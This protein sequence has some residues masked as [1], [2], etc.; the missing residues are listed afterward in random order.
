ML[1][2]ASLKVV[3][4]ALTPLPSFSVGCTVTFL[5]SKKVMSLYFPLRPSIES[6]SQAAKPQMTQIAQM[7]YN[8]F[9]FIMIS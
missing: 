8:M 2:L 5:K 4:K 9:F 6:F 7:I 3:F 1:P